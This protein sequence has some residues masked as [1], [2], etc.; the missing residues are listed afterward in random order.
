MELLEQEVVEFY[1]LPLLIR[2]FR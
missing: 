2:Q 1:C